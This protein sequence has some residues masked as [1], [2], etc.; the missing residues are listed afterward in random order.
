MPSALCFSCASLSL[1]R[2]FPPGGSSLGPSCIA[3]WSFRLDHVGD[4]HSWSFVLT[5]PPS[6]IVLG[7]PSS[8]LG[9][10]FVP[11]LLWALVICLGVRPP[12]ARRIFLSHWDTWR[13]SHPSKASLPVGFGPLLWPSCFRVCLPPV[14]HGLSALCV[15]SSWA[16]SWGLLVGPLCFGI[17]DLPTCFFSLAL[18]LGVV[19]LV[20]FGSAVIAAVHWL[21]ACL[22]C[23]SLA[24]GALVYAPL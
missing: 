15:S 6:T 4:L 5:R 14:S 23:F 18:R 2:L 24:S 8:G 9:C 12:F 11:W 7:C 13:G 22:R 3:F 20:F 1:L 10:G 16:S 17:L 19:I 21:C